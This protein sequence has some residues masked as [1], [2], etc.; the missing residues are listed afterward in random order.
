MSEENDLLDEVAVE[1]KSMSEDYQYPLMFTFKVASM[2]NDFV[3]KDVNGKTLAY[4]RQKMFKLKESVTVYSD[5]SKSS[6]QYMIKANKWLDYN[7]NYAFTR[8]TGEEN[9]GRVGRKGRKSFWKATYEVFDKDGE[10]E[11]TIVE[12]NPWAKVFDNLFGLIG[13]LLFNPRYVVESVDG[14]KIMRLSKQRS[15]VRKFKLEK[16]SEVSPEEGERILLG[17]MMMNLLE[18]RRG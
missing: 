8:G 13:Q 18:K 15:I 17:L 14:T 7:A 12:E 11:Y 9:I 2:A 6:V 16:L 3:A 4:V 10:H 5:Q 1:N